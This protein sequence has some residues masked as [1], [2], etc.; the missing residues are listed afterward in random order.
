MDEGL[1]VQYL[2]DVRETCM[3]GHSGRYC[4]FSPAFGSP[5][6]MGDTPTRKGCAN[7]E[8]Y[9]LA[10]H[11]VKR[12]CNTLVDFSKVVNSTSLISLS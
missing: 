9:F 3:I 2:P 5:M 4:D 1:N 8:S 7:D 10:C 12:R 11:L 6:F